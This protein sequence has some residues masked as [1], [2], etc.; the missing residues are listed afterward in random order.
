MSK[1]LFIVR[2]GKSDWSDPELRDIDRPLKN[3]GVRNAYAMAEYIS[4][5]GIKPEL[6]ISSPAARAINTASIF[7]RVLQMNPNEMIVDER[8][9]HA[10]PGEILDIIYQVPDAVDSIAIFGHNPGYTQLANLFIADHIYNIPTAGVVSLEFDTDNWQD[11]RK[12]KVLDSFFEYPKK[13]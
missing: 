4:A 11:I 5:K 6:F 1:K 10:G 7:F 12:A 9:Y 8:M 3:R 13:L 2:H